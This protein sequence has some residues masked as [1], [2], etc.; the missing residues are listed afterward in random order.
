MKIN[1]KI[2]KYLFTISILFFSSCET[3]DLNLIEDPSKLNASFLD[4]EYTFNYVQLQLPEFVDSSNDFTQRVIRQ[5]AMTGGNT[6]DNAFAPVNFNG[7]WSTGYRMLNA[8]KIMEPKALETKKFYTLGAAK[9]IRCYVLMTLVDMYGDIPYT[10]MLQGNQNL[11]P[12]FDNSAFVYKKILQ[13]IDEAVVL[14][15]TPDSKESPN[16]IDLY[17][18]ES[19]NWVTLANTLK[20]KMYVNSR[21]AA[22]E[23]GIS[24]I[25]L[26]IKTIV[27][28][29]NYID[30]PAEDFAFKYSTTRND[31][32]SRHPLYNDQYELGGGAYISNYIMWAMTIEK[33]DDQ[34]GRTSIVDPRTK[35]YFYKQDSSPAGEDAFTL[36]LGIRPTD[37]DGSKYASFYY[38][39]IKSCYKVSNWFERATPPSGG[40]WGRDHG[41]NSGIP[42]DADK[43][44]VG[45]YYP[46]GGI[47]DDTSKSVQESGTKGALGAG[48]MPIILSSYVHFM[49]AEAYY[50][51]PTSTASPLADAKSE[52]FL[53]ITQSIDKSTTVKD[54]PQ[55]S[56]AQNTIINAVPAQK[57]SYLSVL[58]IIYDDLS[59][60]KKLEFILKEYYI[61]AWG[62]G[63]EPYNNYRRTGFPSNFQPTLEPESGTFFST[64]FYPASSI[65]NNPNCPSSNRTRKVFWDKANINLH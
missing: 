52:L 4:P 62:N 23:I 1:N 20:L 24:D 13:E 39:S 19:K 51:L 34:S 45:G 8:I 55:I 56:G 10:D 25:G 42:P 16:F 30:T 6:Y 18:K 11:T 22:T 64:A 29:N 36:P 41:D 5:M 48:I 9:L 57:T 33:G 26:A 32:N 61:A 28:D 44:S 49:L 21:L 40:Y 43:R 58:N 14:L 50:T 17:Y 38:P 37:Y 53:G 12:R 54:Y 31:P 65:N 35:F 2:Y 63:I 15:K 47:L 60:F 27:T 46:I 7:N 3:V 59:N